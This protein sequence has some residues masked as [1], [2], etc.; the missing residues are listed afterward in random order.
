MLVLI[1]FLTIVSVCKSQ[2]DNHKQDQL[3]GDVSNF[4]CTSLDKVENIELLMENDQI[5]VNW[6]E[7]DYN[8]TCSI[9]YRL[10]MYNNHKE[11]VYSANTT[12]TAHIVDFK[13]IGCMIYNLTILP[14]S[15]NVEGTITEISV[16]FSKKVNA[17]NCRP[18][19]IKETS[20]IFACRLNTDKN[21]LCEVTDFV[22]YCKSDD[23]KQ[24]N[25]NQSVTLLL[26]ETLVQVELA[27]LSGFT[28]YTCQTITTDAIGEPIRLQ[29]KAGVPGSPILKSVSLATNTSFTI[30][31]DLP[32][33]IPGI[34][35]T[36]NITVIEK[37]P[38]Y[39]LPDYC[40]ITTEK[41]YGGEVNGSELMYTVTDLL[42]SWEYE[43]FVT[44]KTIEYGAASEAKLIQTL[45]G[46]MIVYPKI[47]ETLILTL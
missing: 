16:I 35:K 28:N 19:D 18:K 24:T 27:N 31:W 6:K 46:S 10:E 1:A 14:T 8:G 37:R 41:H 5:F 30:A 21:S 12:K 25:V 26:N 34:L 2:D 36:F 44:A 22:I 20:I 39:F 40:N 43:V 42:P 32:L 29:T 23:N 9:F 11:K 15:D 7:P 4:T 47:Q 38:L 17:L 3:V 33:H 13:F 45:G